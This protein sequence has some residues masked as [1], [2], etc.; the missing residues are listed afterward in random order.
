MSDRRRNT[1]PHVC[2][3][4]LTTT[5]NNMTGSTSVQQ[6]QQTQQGQQAPQPRRGLSGRISALSASLRVAREGRTEDGFGTG[7]R[8]EDERTLVDTSGVTRLPS[9]HDHPNQQQHFSGR[10]GHG[11]YHASSPPP[12]TTT[13][14]QEFPWARGRQRTRGAGPSAL[15]RGGYGN[16]AGH[17]PHT[18]NGAYSSHEQ[19]IL[20]THAHTRR[21][22]IPIGRGGYGNIAHA[23]ALAAAEAETRTRSRSVDPVQAPTAMSFHI[24]LPVPGFSH[25]RARPGRSKPHEGFYLSSDSDSESD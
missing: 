13:E 12:L 10:A 5:N 8:E 19:E 23:R 3:L 22:A 6:Q 2:P 24:P 14:E 15:G 4:L 1:P 21:M 17:H 9:Y 11:N 18:A 25:R 20:R 16:I 7:R